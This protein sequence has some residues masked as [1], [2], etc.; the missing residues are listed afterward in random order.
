MAEQKPKFRILD[1]AAVVETYANK[2]IGS[3]FDGGAVMLT[4]GTTR[5]IPPNRQMRNRKKVTTPSFTSLLV[6]RFLHRAPSN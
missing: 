6:W 5:F 3:S 4:F 1:N 2:F